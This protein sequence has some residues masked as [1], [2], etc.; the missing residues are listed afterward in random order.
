MT[1]HKKGPSGCGVTESEPSVRK[2]TSRRPIDQAWKNPSGRGGENKRK[3]G[4]PRHLTSVINVVVEIVWG[5][6]RHNIGREESGSRVEG[7]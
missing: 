5:V 3:S 7:G 4:E 6:N 1:C 2:N